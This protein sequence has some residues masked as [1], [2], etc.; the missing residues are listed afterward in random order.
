MGEKSATPDLVI[1]GIAR[2]QHGMVAMRQIEAAGIGR[3]AVA[4]RARTGRL[5][6][7]HHGVYAV[8]HM[9]L[10]NEAGWM[11]AVLACGRGGLSLTDE[12]TASVLDY[13]GAVL[14]H[15]GAAELWRMLPPREGAVDVTVPGKGGKGKRK[16]IRLHRSA[17]L[18]PALVTLRLGIPVTTP[19]RTIADLRRAASRGRS[20][21]AKEL[22]RAIRQADVLGLPIEEVDGRDR[23]RSDLERDFLRLCRRHRLPVPE[24]NVLVGPYLV[25]FL[26][27]DRRVAVETDSYLYHRGRVAFQDDRA[28]ALE[29]RAR[30]FDVVPLSE[31]QVNEEAPHVADVLRCALRVGA[32]A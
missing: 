14:S 22:R 1:A 13:W 9:A 23:T 12:A 15:R 2:R 5:H 4:L 8:G 31:K 17:T 6:R 25:D 28:R 27:R 29:L 30:G 16:G 18:A 21:S 24:V 26:W 20:I 7:V 3:N 32:D 11:A 10:S 19:A